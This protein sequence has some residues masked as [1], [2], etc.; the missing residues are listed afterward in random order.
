[1]IRCRLNRSVSTPVKGAR[2]KLGIS[3]EKAMNPN[4]NTEPDNRYTSQ[5]SAIFCIQDP[6]R[7]MP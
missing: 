5:L 1:M 2:M 4:R 7:E 3:V 6:V